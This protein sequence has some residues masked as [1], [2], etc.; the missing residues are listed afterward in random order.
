MDQVIGLI[1]VGRYRPRQLV[2]TNDGQIVGGQLKKTAIELQ[3]SSGQVTSIP[4]SQITRIGY[5]RQSAEPAEWNFEGKALVMTRDGERV[6]IQLPTAPVEV[7]TRYGRLELKPEQIGGI[8][9]QNDDSGVHEIELT[10]GSRFAGLMGA[11]E[12][13]AQLLMA[14][15]QTAQFPIGQISRIQF[16]GKVAESDDF[17]P[18]FHLANEDL[19]V[20]TLAGTLKLDTAF[21]TISVNGAEVKS[22]DRLAEGSRD[23]QVVMWDGATLSGQVE[24]PTVDCRL[25]S[26][27]EMSIPVPLLEHYT[28]PQP[29]PSAE[30]LDRIR[31]AIKD[32]SDPDWKRRDR[33]ASVLTRMGPVVEGSLNEMRV[34]QPEEAQRSIDNILA[35]LEKQRQQK[36]ASAVPA[37]VPVPAAN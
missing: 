34:N 5:R 17:T 14:K 8:I 6:A 37:A 25:K 13:S 31:T 18:M 35:G 22:M 36:P 24:S 27:V 2:I 19:L 12:V 15:G 20:G 3:L 21:D 11:D 29:A 16:A 23:V 4:L 7:L 26:G 1:N 30:M 9:L 10:D 33:A 28:Q 32:L